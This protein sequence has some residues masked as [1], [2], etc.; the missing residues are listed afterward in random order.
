M[1]AAGIGEGTGD[2]QIRVAADPQPPED[3][4]DV[5][6]TVDDRGVGLLGPDRV[7]G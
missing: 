7:G 6:V 1:D 4:Q 2:L 3:L 5:G